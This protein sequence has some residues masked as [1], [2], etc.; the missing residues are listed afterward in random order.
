MVLVVCYR[1]AVA[2]AV[3]EADG[4]GSDVCTEMS[5]NCYLLHSNHKDLGKNSQETCSLNL[6]LNMDCD[7]GRVFHL[8]H[9]CRQWASVGYSSVPLQ[10]LLMNHS[11]WVQ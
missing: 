2:A 6:T 9:H 10:L 7:D 8:K 3:D 5:D 11:V 1:A 4:G